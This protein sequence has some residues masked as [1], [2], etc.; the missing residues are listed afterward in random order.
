VNF[1]WSGQHWVQSAVLFLLVQ[2]WG[3]GL[4]DIRSRLMAFRLQAAQRLLYYGDIAWSNTAVALLRKAGNMGLD[5]HLFL[6]N[7]NET[8]LADL[9]PFYRSVMEDWKVFCLKTC[10]ITCRFLADGGAI[11]SESLFYLQYTCALSMCHH[12]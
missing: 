9:S 5:K 3:Q 6:L 1:F 4:V 7:L 2:E 8:T 11:V 10:W 12:D